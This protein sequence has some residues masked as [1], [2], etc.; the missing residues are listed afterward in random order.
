MLNAPTSFEPVCD[1]LEQENVEILRDLPANGRADF[2]I[3]FVTKK[4]QI[5]SFAPNIV[6]TLTDD[7]V[8]WFAY[9]K[10]SSKNINSGITRDDGWERLTALGYKPVRQIAIDDDWSALRF[11]PKD[12]V[13]SR[14]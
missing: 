2:L 3:M 5:E 14:I 12:L 8:L 7:P 9:P 1:E 13:K 6:A 4:D 11:R 10:L